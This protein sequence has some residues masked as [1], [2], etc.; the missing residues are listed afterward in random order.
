VESAELRITPGQF[1]VLINRRDYWQI[2]HIIPKGAYERVRT[3]GL[4]VFRESFATGVPDLAD[5]A[6]EIQDWDQIKLLTVRADR[7]RRWYQPGLLCI[8][9]AAHAMSPVLGVGI[10]VAIQDAVEAANLLWSPLRRGDVQVQHL[11]RVQR[12]RELAV[13]ITQA[14]Q[15]IMQQWIVAPHL[16]DP[17]AEPSVPLI[18]RVGTRL[19]LVR[20][21]PGQI[22]GMGLWRTR[23]RAPAIAP[24][25]GTGRR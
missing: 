3:E 20:D 10:N 14:F 19:P 13:R 4:D 21:L 16:A 1:F 22:V 25:N 6:T 17:R 2:A 15:G 8:G 18:L 24:L 11:A 23:V 12:R 7:L 5:R 9:D